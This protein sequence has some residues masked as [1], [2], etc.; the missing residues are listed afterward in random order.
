MRARLVMLGYRVFLCSLTTSLRLSHFQILVTAEFASISIA[1]KIVIS[2]A[3][4]CAQTTPLA[5]SL[6]LSCGE[7]V[8]L[9]LTSTNTIMRYL[10]NL[11]P[12]SH[13]MGSTN[14]EKAQ[15]DSWLEYIWCSL[16]I[17]IGAGEGNL[18]VP[19]KILE[20]HLR[21]RETA[22]CLVGND[23]SIAD[24]SLVVSL[25]MASVEMSQYE[26]LK[27]LCDKVQKDAAFQA[28]VALLNKTPES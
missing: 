2:Q 8:D 24:I 3:E 11:V 23:I 16:D 19:L 18:S 26:S 21:N 27:R 13:L 5:K 15:V 22:T 17:P 25:Y 6:V 20:K 14:V 9:Y 28:A 10:A 4:L 7:H 1:R 12:Q